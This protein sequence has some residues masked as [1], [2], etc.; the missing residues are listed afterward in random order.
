MAANG[1]SSAG[2]GNVG[3]GGSSN[4]GG[5]TGTGG[6]SATD[7]AAG[8]GT[9]G[10]SATGGATG[11]G[12]GGSA[13]TTLSNNKAINAL[14]AAEG[15]QLCNNTYAYFGSAIPQATTC[16]W[17]GLAYAVQS[18]APSDTVLQQQCTKQL[19][20]CQ[21]AADPWANNP[22]CNTLPADCTATVAQYS[23]CI[24]DEATAFMQTVSGL[25]TCATVTMSSTSSITDAQLA[26][27]PASCASLMDACPDLYPPSPLNQ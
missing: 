25:P 27:P 15:T 26:A 3:T 12:T 18:S 10:S 7:G 20:S 21:Q 22:G 16:K 4:A 6:S 1:C 17:Q 14:T 9:G 13:V 23:T 2:G 8:R 5:A 19:N 24:S 11:T